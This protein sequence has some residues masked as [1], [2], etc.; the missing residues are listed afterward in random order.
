MDG[1]MDDETYVMSCN[2]MS[3]HRKQLYLSSPPPQQE[4]VRIESKRNE[5]SNFY[6]STTTNNIH[7]HDGS[8]IAPRYEETP[9]S[10]YIHTTMTTRHRITYNILNIL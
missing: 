1:W 7:Y 10:Y 8:L 9:A 2:V 3:C 4:Q 6:R 5:P